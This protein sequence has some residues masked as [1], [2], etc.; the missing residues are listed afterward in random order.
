MTP[1]VEAHL[2]FSRAKILEAE[3]ILEG[4]K[5]WAVVAHSAYLAALSAA[6]A[7]VRHRTG[8]TPKT[9]SGTQSEISRLA[10]FDRRIDRSF[11]AFLAR[12]YEIKSDVDYGDQEA[13]EVTREEAADALA[14]TTRFVAHAEW[15]LA[16]PEPPAAP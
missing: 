15:L 5:Q 1:E 8:K 6:R 4:T 11:S 14:T 3:D 16:Q 12:G 9:H 10:Q 7:I 13:D 2:A